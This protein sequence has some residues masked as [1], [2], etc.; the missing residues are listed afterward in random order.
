VRPQTWKDVWD[1]RRIDSSR[2]TVLSR[3]LAADG[4]DTGFG[5]VEE[6]PWRSYV[7][8]AATAIGIH[9]ESSVFEVGCGA[10]AWLYEL[11]RLGC[12]IGGLDASPA[13]IGYAREHLPAGR[14]LQGDAST[15]ETVPRYDFVVSSGVFLYFPS[16]EYAQGVLDLMVSKARMGVLVLDVPDLATRD[17]ATAE[18]HRIAGEESYRRRYDGLD[19]LYF[20]RSWFQSTLTSLGVPRIRIENQCIDGYSNSRYR[21]NVFAWLR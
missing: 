10:G 5:S 16:L 4:M 15:L 2:P 1:A 6:K 12:E 9:A 19:H 7:L 14:W 20:D 13:L 21:F 18:R 11:S 3:L 8:K 17:A